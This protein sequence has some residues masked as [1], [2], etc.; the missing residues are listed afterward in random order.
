MLHVL[1]AGNVKLPA[2]A[3]VQDVKRVLRTKWNVLDIRMKI[4]QPAPAVGGARLKR[5][6]AHL[7]TLRELRALQLSNSMSFLPRLLAP[8]NSS[9]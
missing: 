3:N 2:P 9:H 5:P 1:P 7:R 4:V 6:R 8:T